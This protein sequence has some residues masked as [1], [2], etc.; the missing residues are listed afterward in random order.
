M[1]IPPPSIGLCPSYTVPCP[2]PVTP[3]GPCPTPVFLRLT[4][5]V[6]V[7]TSSYPWTLGVATSYPSLHKT[8]FPLDNTLP[9]LILR[10][11]RYRPTSGEMC[12]EKSKGVSPGTT[13]VSRRT[14]SVARTSTGRPSPANLSTSRQ[15]PSYL[16]SVDSYPARVTNM[17]KTSLRFLLSNYYVVLNGGLSCKSSTWVELYTFTFLVSSI[18]CTS[19]DR[20]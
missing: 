13:R 5:R 14:G 8:H 12:M 3:V 18:Y 10:V 7:F 20:Q 4:K 11:T 2:T 19:F 15:S 9:S 6:P 1:H 17:T 16:V